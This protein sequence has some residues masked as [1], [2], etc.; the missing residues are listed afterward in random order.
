ME[1]H[2]LYNRSIPHLHGFYYVLPYVPHLY[3]IPLTTQYAPEYRS[4]LNR[5]K[6]HR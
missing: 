2:R 6:A 5:L 3:I 4:T 1:H